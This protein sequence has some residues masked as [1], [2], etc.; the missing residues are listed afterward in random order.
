MLLC[1]L[2]GL[3]HGAVGVEGLQLLLDAHQRVGKLAIVEDNDCLLD[4]LQQVRGQR[5]VLL[6]HLLCLD[7]VVQH[8][9]KV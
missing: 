1:S 5:L 2:G 6:D 7:G 3:F 9:A 8:L 4:P